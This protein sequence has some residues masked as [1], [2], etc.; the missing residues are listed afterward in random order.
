VPD[1]VRRDSWCVS[2]AIDEI[3]IK[4]EL[5]DERIDLL[6]RQRHRWAAFEIAAEEAIRR[7]AELESGF[8]G[9]FDDGG[10]VFLRQR[11]RAEDATDAGFPF[12]PVDV[13]ADRADRRPSQRS[14]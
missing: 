14:R 1:R 5:P 2:G 9:V 10:A 12:M 11:E 6:E 8:G 4:G 13:I 3:A 7:H